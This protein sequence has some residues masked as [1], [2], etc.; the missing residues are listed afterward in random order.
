MTRVFIDSD[1]VIDY[2]TDREPFAGP[3]SAIFE[4]NE[5][6]EIQLYI[7]AVSITNIYYIVRRY[8]GQK[9]SLKVIRELKEI[10]ELVGVTK[11]E[12]LEALSNGFG[13]FEDGIQHEVAKTVEGIQVI[14]TRN[15]KDYKHSQ[16]PVFTPDQYLLYR[17]SLLVH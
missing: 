13:D 7:S 17:K 4:L 8:L 12:I 1:V 15:L 11:F 5:Q 9:E 16:I 3:A 14:L 6:G 10:T 2:F